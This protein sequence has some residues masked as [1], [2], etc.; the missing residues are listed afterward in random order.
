[1]RGE[2]ASPRR[3]AGAHG[4]VLGRSDPGIHAKKAALRPQGGAFDAYRTLV[5]GQ[6]PGGTWIFLKRSLEKCA[7]EAPGAG[8]RAF[9]GLEGLRYLGQ[10][11]ASEDPK[12]HDAG[13]GRVGGLQL[14]DG[15]V[16]GEQVD[17]ILGVAHAGQGGLEHAPAAL[18]GRPVPG[19]VDEDLPHGLGIC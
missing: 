19:V 16:Q 11:E 2:I 3:R 12:H 18:L 7:S 6:S 5:C 17:G 4:P 1:V 9:A 14:L 8:R 15:L 13:G 10:G